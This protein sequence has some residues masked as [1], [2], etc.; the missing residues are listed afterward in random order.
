[1]T[2]RKWYHYYFT[3]GYNT[4]TNLSAREIKGLELDHGK[5]L[6]KIPLD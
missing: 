2:K 3:D 1:M 6:A 4:I 5:L